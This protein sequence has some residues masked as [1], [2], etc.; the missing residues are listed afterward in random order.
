MVDVEELL[1]EGKVIQIPLTGLSMYPFLI[2][3]RD[4]VI[5]EPA[6]EN[7]AFR[8]GEVL[9]YRRAGSILV[10]HRL[11]RQDEKGLYMCGDN[12]SEIEGPL[13]RKQIRGRMV[14]FVRKGKERSVAY[15]PYRLL[16]GLWRVF[17]P[18]RPAA[19]GLLR[20]FRRLFHITP[21]N[22]ADTG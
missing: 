15:V 3:G 16:T 18:L 5:L 7:D 1:G 20:F 8:K 13:M 2:G 10:L 12:Q 21:K 6:S 22:P 19:W 9:L 14:G 4:K 11:I 17:L